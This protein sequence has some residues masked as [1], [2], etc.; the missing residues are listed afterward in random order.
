MEWNEFVDNV[1]NWSRERGIYEHS[2]PDAQLLKALSEVGELADAYAKQDTAG[3]IDGIGDVLVCLVNYQTMVGG[4]DMEPPVSG[5]ARIGPWTGGAERAIG[6]MAV[7]IGA[8][9][10]EEDNKELL[11]FLATGMIVFSDYY[12][13][14]NITQCLQTAWDAIKGR[15]GKVVPGGVFIKEVGE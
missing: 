2:T 10:G 3:V 1:Q 15:H 14:V 5:E 4:G 11:P 8:Y 12:M 9:I 7:S 13:K 6:Q